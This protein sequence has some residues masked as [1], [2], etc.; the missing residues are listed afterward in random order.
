MSNRITKEESKTIFLRLIWGIGFF[1]IAL[2]LREWVILQY[3]S[4]IAFWLGIGIVIAI[5]YMYDLRLPYWMR[6]GK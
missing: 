4:G 1:F 2:S 3:G 6:N 5:A